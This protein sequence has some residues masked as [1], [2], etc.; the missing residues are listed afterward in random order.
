[1]ARFMIHW[2]APDPTNEKYTQAIVDYIKGGKPMDEYAGFKVLA[3]QIHPH[4]GGGCLLVEADNLVKV[5]KHTYP[6][7][8]GLGITATIT[9]GLSDEE[10]VELEE[11]KKRKSVLKSIGVENVTQ[12]IAIELLSL[13]K[14]LG[15]HPET[16]EDVLA[17][18]GPYGPYVKCGKINASMK[19]DESPLTITLENALKLIKDRKLKFEPKVLGEHPKTKNEISIKRGRFG[20]YVTDGKKN[21]S[22][23]GYVV[24]EVTLD[25]AVKLID[26]KS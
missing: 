4:L 13:P 17:D 11:S 15:T 24:D 20:P 21:V 22:L 5:Q 23:K 6:W 25:Q 10:Y 1:M 8:K 7:T 9:P 18:F 14:K 19:S 16:N 2:C 3:R 12:E 26:E